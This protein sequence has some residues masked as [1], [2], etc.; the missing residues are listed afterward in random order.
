[1]KCNKTK[2]WGQMFTIQLGRLKESKC[3]TVNSQCKMKKTK[4]KKIMKTIKSLSNKNK[5][6][7]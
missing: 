1:M 5:K 7:S 3:Y 2:W 4:M 6:R